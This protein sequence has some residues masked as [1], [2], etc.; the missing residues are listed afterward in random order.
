MNGRPGLAPGQEVKGM[1][2][3]DVAPLIAHLLGLEFRSPDGRLLPALTNK[4]NPKK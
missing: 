2:I 1:G 4:T 3:Q